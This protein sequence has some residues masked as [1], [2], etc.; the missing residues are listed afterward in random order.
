MDATKISCID[1]TLRHY[2]DTAQV[3]SSDNLP[4][5]VHWGCQCPHGAFQ[6]FM[7]ALSQLEVGVQT[8]CVMY[9]RNTYTNCFHFLF[10]L[11]FNIPKSFSQIYILFQ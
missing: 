5:R 3:C 11:W 7:L 2:E 4:L 10:D 1:K 9:T 6:K 8:E